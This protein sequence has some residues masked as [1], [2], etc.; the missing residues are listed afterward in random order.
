[1]NW[2]S[3][4]HKSWEWLQWMR[5][6]MD[7]DVGP[8]ISLPQLIRGMDQWDDAIARDR[9]AVGDPDRIAHNEYFLYAASMMSRAAKQGID[10]ALKHAMTWE[11]DNPTNWSAV[12][13][14]AKAHW[15]AA[16]HVIANSLQAWITLWQDLDGLQGQISQTLDPHD[17]HNQW[18]DVTEQAVQTMQGLASAFWVGA[19]H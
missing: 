18:M 5:E 2:I 11:V 17:R 19:H 4:G 10:S 13:P 9:H 3:E 14:E 6:V 8:M 7:E 1:M 15:K 16:H 12:L